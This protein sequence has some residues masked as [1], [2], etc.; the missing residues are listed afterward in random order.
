LQLNSTKLL[1]LL[2]PF[3]T[4]VV[5]LW[6]WRH[7]QMSWIAYLALATSVN[8]AKINNSMLHMHDTFPPAFF[9]VTFYSCRVNTMIIQVKAS[10]LA[11][12]LKNSLCSLASWHDHACTA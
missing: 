8:Y 7:Q 2:R 12:Y 11:T 6:F 1:Y 5:S 3:S 9:T 4:V 10:K